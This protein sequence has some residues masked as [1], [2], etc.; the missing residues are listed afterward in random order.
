VTA[1][2]FLSH[3]AERKVDGGRVTISADGITAVVDGDVRVASGAIPS[4]ILCEIGDDLYPW[5]ACR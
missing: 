5:P 2:P 4:W 3:D 1:A